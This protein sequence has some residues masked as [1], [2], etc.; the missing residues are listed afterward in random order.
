MTFEERACTFP[1]EGEQLVGIASIPHASRSRGVVVAV[2]GPQYRVGSHRQFTLLARHLA[3][4]GVPT[5]RFDYRGMGDSSGDRRSFESVDA[6]IRAAIDHLQRESVG[7]DEVVL[8]GLCDAAS[9]AMMFA[10]TDSRVAGL[11]L[12]N[13]W[14]RSEATLA[15]TH[16]KHYYAERLLQPDLWR[17]VTRGEFELRRSLSGLVSSLRAVQSRCEQQA[18]ETFQA[19]MARGMRNFRG[20]A[21]LLLAGNDLTAKEFLEHT[22]AAPEWQGVLAGERVSRRDF[23]RSDHTFS[24]RESRRQVEDATL[25]WVGSW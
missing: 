12:L 9:A 4:H 8:W 22:A 13:P 15:K 14:A 6:D 19:R 2:G 5:L 25:Q 20:H 11:V 3:C 10:P 16:L 18:S 17:K 24:D 7:V 23:P 21:L 1:C